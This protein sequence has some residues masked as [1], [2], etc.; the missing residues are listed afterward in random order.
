MSIGISRIYKSIIISEIFAAGIVRW[1]D[2]DNVNL[3]SMGLFQQPEAEG[4]RLQ[5]EN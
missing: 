3:A 2:V 4:Y 5:E 1:I